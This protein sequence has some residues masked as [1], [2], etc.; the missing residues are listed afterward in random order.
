MKSDLANLGAVVEALLPFIRKSDCVPG[1]TETL[2]HSG[3]GPDKALPRNQEDPGKKF[4]SAAAADQLR[5]YP[6]LS[7]MKAKGLK[8]DCRFMPHRCERREIPQSAGNSA[9][10]NIHG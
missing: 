3:S 7:G 10:A 4:T 1:T 9:D 8:A 5:K 2:T 6:S